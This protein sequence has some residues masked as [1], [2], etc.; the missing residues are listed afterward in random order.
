MIKIKSYFFHFILKEKENMVKDIKVKNKLLEDII[1][2]YISKIVEDSEKNVGFEETCATLLV[3]GEGYDF[4]ANKIEIDEI[5]YQN[6][7]KIKGAITS[8]ELYDRPSL[9]SGLTEVALS[10]YTVYKKTGYYKKFLDKINQLLIE[11]TERYLKYIDVKNNISTEYFDA[12][13]GIS[14]I[15]KYLLLFT[16]EEKMNNLSVKLLNILVYM[17]GYKKDGELLLPRWHIKKENLRVERDRVN[18]P[19]GYLN[20]G[21]AHGIA[22][23]LMVLGES[24][25]KGI[26]VEN[27]LNAIA[28]IVNE[29]K[30][31][32]YEL[33]GSTYWPNML[34][35]EQFL[36]NQNNFHKEV[37][38]E[39]WCYGAIGIAKVLLNTGICI[40]DHKLSNWALSI[41]EQKSQLEIKELLL[42]SPTLCHGYAGVLSI[43]KSTYNIQASSILKQ[44]MD[45]IGKQIINMYDENSQYGFWNIESSKNIG[46]IRE[47]KNTFLD[48]TAGIILALLYANECIGDTFMNKL[49]I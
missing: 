25:K 19:T 21:V 23:P 1:D 49:V 39:S 43:L 4:F 30:R 12:I 27:H 42:N 5:I 7:L 13:Y 14:G 11:W 41:I 20:F 40:E 47:D 33:N 28:N 8:G 29:Y 9:Y 15:T 31:C 3:L 37:N 38:N 2:K 44:G 45:K 32:V 6:M 16:E 34:S 36:D 48:G 17:S 10:I 26:I 24:Y 46:E 18:Y 22:G 35:P